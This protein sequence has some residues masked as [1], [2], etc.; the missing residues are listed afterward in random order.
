[1]EISALGGLD[2]K[3][4][5]PLLQNGTKA[6]VVMFPAMRSGRSEKN[7]VAALTPTNVNLFVDLSKLMLFALCTNRNSA[8]LGSWGACASAASKGVSEVAAS[9]EAAT[10]NSRRVVICDSLGLRDECDFLHDDEGRHPA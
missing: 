9:A 8:S 4:S 1:M 6:A 7:T 5:L 10:N 2:R 3:L